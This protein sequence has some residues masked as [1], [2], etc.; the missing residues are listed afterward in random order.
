[1]FSPKR[2]CCRFTIPIARRRSA[3]ATRYHPGV[4]SKRRFGRGS[5]WKVRAT[6]P[7]LRILTGRVTSP[8]LISQI[9]GLMKSLPQAKWYRYE[10]VEDDAVRAGAV[11]AFG[12]PLTAIPRFADAR[13]R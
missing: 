4:R 10:P 7:G 6:A 13:W 8:T 1:M 2:R 5:N 12:M 9:D 11:Q 3:A